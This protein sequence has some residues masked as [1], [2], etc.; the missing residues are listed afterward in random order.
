MWNKKIHLLNVFQGCWFGSLIPVSW[1]TVG[2]RHL[3]LEIFINIHLKK[4]DKNLKHGE[5]HLNLILLISIS[6]QQSYNEKQKTCF[7]LL[8]L[9]IHST[10]E[11]GW[12]RFVTIIF[13]RKLYILIFFSNRVLRS[14]ID[15]NEHKCIGQISW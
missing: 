12:S 10:S 2:K 7:S 13:G 4:N 9:T 6:L 11:Y 5:I 1:S 15:S 8:F 14:A 3:Q